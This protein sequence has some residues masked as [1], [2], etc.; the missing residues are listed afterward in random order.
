MRLTMQDQI[1]AHATRSNAIR[2]ACAKGLAEPT[3]IWEVLEA[4]GIDVTPGVIH[5]AIADLQKPPQKGTAEQQARGPWPH[6]VMGLTAEDMDSLAAL[7]GKAGGVERL[8][9]FL[10]FMQRASL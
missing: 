4:K 3:R 1:T 6:E 7:A 5:R 2:E 9:R 8:A 10:G